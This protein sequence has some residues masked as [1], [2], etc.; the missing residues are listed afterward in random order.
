M[1]KKKQRAIEQAESLLKCKNECKNT[2]IGKA[3]DEAKDQASKVVDK[4][5]ES[6]PCA[7]ELAKLKQQ[8]NAIV[9]PETKTTTAQGNKVNPTK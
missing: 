6:G 8:I 1:E 7:P 9:A 2:A 4:C 3:I 5:D